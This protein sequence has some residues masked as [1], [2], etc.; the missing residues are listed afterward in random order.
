[1]IEWWDSLPL[2]LKVFYSIGIISLAVVAL[3]MLLM[4]LG[5]DTDGIAD[6][7]DVDFGDGYPS[8]SGIGLFSSQTI[9]AFFLAFGWA[10]VLAIKGGASIFISALIAGICGFGAMF[11]MLYLMRAMLRL[12]SKGNLD[13]TNAIGREATVYVT[14]P[15]N[16]ED[17]GGQ[18]QV[19]IQGRLT[20]AGAR[21]VD[22]GAIKPGERVRIVDVNGPA[23]F[24][25]EAL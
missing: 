1:M 9:S 23:S 7:F 21:K 8:D 6:G 16:N 24:V 13:Y 22:E 25:V 5:F 14:L 4:L 20:T 17:G 11:A 15:G 3:Q 2:E 12:Q 18:I 10:G 19:V